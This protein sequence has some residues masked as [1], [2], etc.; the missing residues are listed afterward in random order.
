M[1]PPT[2]AEFFD[3]RAEDSRCMEVRATMDGNDTS[4][5]REN[6]A[7]LIVRVAPLDGFLQV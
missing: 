2:L 1:S 6:A 7:G 5:L 4:R 3:G